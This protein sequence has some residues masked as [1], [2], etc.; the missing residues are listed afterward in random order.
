[1]DLKFVGFALGGLVVGIGVMYYLERQT[2]RNIKLDNLAEKSE[3][4]G[5]EADVFRMSEI[6]RVWG[7]SR[8][9]RDLPARQIPTLGGAQNPYLEDSEFDPVLHAGKKGRLY[10]DYGNASFDPAAVD[11]NK[12][13]V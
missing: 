1:M 10:V 4:R 7:Q 8:P 5:K 12:N 9:D 11:P 6:K 2:R 13:V 3:R